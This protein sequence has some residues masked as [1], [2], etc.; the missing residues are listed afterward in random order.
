MELLG[1]GWLAIFIVTGLIAGLVDSIA[2]GGG[3]ITLPVL[4]KPRVDGRPG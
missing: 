2:G 3:L 1:A 4:I